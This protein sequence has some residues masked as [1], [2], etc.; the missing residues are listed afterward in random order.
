M[1]RILGRLVTIVG[2]MI[3]LVSFCFLPYLVVPYTSFTFTGLQLVNLGSQIPLP[4]YFVLQIRSPV[5]QNIPGVLQNDPFVQRLLVLVVLMGLSAVGNLWAR[6][7]WNELM[8]WVIIVGASITFPFALYSLTSN[9]AAGFDFM[10]ARANTLSGIVHGSLFTVGFLG[11]LL[12]VI[13]AFIGGVMTLRSKDDPAHS[14][15]QNAEPP[16]PSP[17]QRQDSQHG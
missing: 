3:S 15:S 14:A 7:G 2:C 11:V 5:V 12:G 9:V 10:D 8:A 17:V 6:R 13:V 4:H 1:F 16:L